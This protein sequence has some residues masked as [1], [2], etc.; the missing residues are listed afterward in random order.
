MKH[1]ESHV[2]QSAFYKALETEGYPTH[3]KNELTS[4]K[5]INELFGGHV[6]P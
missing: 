4:F 6:N 2:S 3:L 1:P 5:K